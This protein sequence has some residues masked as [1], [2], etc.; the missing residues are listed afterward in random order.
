L[1]TRS[2]TVPRNLFPANE[3]VPW[4]QSRSPPTFSLR[5]PWNPT[6]LVLGINTER[7]S[8]TINCQREDHAAVILLRRRWTITPKR[9][10]P[11]CRTI[12][13]RSP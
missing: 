11:A 12:T 1:P 6:S 13:A 5:T 8:A 4:T 9:E 3:T 7:W 10:T 2:Q